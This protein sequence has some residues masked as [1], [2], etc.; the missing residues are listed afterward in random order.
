MV[1]TLRER[2]RELRYENA[3]EV[4][5]MLLA[6]NYRSVYHRYDEGPKAELEDPYV[7]SPSPVKKDPVQVLSAINCLEYQSCEHPEWADS[8][9]KA[10]L[11]ALAHKAILSLPG[12]DDTMWEVVVQ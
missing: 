6:E 2:H 11:D 9:A 1:Q 12:Y 3:T 8:E 4:G 5:R 10:F 7:Y